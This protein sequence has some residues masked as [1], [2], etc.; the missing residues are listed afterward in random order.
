MNALRRLHPDLAPRFH[1]STTS[2]LTQRVLA[3]ALLIVGANLNTQPA[4][5][6][7]VVGEIP[8]FVLNNANDD[9]VMM[10]NGHIEGTTVEVRL[11]LNMSV[12][13]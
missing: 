11:P 8:D 9:L 10:P 12:A 5:H 13:V 7:R 1:R 3:S 2:A 6:V 4:P